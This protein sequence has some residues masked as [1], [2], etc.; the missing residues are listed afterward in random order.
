MKKGKVIEKLLAVLS[1]VLLG[2]G[3]GIA[4]GGCTATSLTTSI[5]GL[6]M[7][8]IGWASLKVVEKIG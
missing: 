8:V 5:T 6:A 4:I 1:S 2:G 3:A 7:M